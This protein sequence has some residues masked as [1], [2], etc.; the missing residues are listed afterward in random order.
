[1]GA[2]TRLGLL[3]NPLRDRFGIPLR[4]QFY[5][6]KD[7]QTVIERAAG[8]MGMAIDKKGSEEIAKRSRGTPR[9]AVRLLRRVRDFALA[10]QVKTVTRECADGAL[11]RLEVDLLGLDSADRRYMLYVAEHYSGGPVGIETIAAGLSEQRDTLEET[12]EPFLMQV[13]FIQRT[14]RG[15]MLTQKAFA[16]LGMAAPKGLAGQ[17]DLL[18]GEE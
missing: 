8:L 10:D 13:G 6:V 2:T 14:Q 3:S 9:I 12:I 11:Q 7:L 15:R 1:M 18:E 4:L 17:M 5:E 16:H